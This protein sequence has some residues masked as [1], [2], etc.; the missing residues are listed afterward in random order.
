M[1]NYLVMLSFCFIIMFPGLCQAGTEGAMSVRIAH[2]QIK[3]DQLEA[4]TLAVKEE[5]EAALRLEPGVVAIYAVADKNDPTKLTFFEIYINDEAYD[6]HRET[7]HFKKYFNI[8][9]DMISSRVLM[10]G[11]P[12][13][14]RDKHNTP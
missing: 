1:R 8:T 9:K 14:M 10:E 13:E 3:S 4:F 12:V 11:V 6:I 2:L 5:M 7:P